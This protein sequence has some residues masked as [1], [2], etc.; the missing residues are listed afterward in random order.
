MNT[1][2]TKSGLYIR[3][4]KGLAVRDR[5]VQRLVRKM[6]AV[7]PW[8]TESDV[9][10]CR[11]WAQLEILGDHAFSIL[12]TIGIIDRQGD[13]KRLLTDWR[14][15]KLAQLAYA[16]ELG[17]TPAAMKLLRA[18][19]GRAPFDLAAAMA[20]GEV[21]EIEPDKSARSG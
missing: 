21:E 2:A 12:R 15:L 20:G 5:K 17:M 4:A 3:S 7:M 9:P 19:S 8:L 6:L 10:T 18:N 1:P 11:G 16:K 14:Q 13:P